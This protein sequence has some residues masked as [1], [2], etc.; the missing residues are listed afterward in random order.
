M[1]VDIDYTRSFQFVEHC[2]HTDTHTHT[3]VSVFI[4][5]PGSTL[6][7]YTPYDKAVLCLRSIVCATAKTY[8]AQTVL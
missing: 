8:S 7:V 2:E 4:I 3:V 6:N 1:D 5:W